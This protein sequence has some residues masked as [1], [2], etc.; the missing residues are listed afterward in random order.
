MTPDA[1][2][3]ATLERLFALT[4]FGEKL[5][6]STPRA[7]NAALGDPLGAYRSVLIGGTNGKGSTSAFL[8]AILRRAGLK[9]GLFTSPHLISFQERIRIDGKDLS[10]ESV[11]ALAE[12]IFALEALRPSFFEATWAMAA[13][14]FALAG[15]DVAIFEVGLGGRLDATNTCDPAASAVVSVGLDHTQVLGDTLE[16]IAFEKAGIFR[17]GRPALTADPVALPLLQRAAP[18][19]VAL[20]RPQP[21]LPPLPLPGAFQRG[22]AALALALAASIGVEPDVAALE[23]VRWPGRGERIGNVILDCAHNPHAAEAL[24]DWLA[25]RV[26]S[27]LHLIFGAMRGK[28]VAGVLAPLAPHVASAAVVTP[29]YPRR[30]AAAEVLPTARA[31][32]PAAEDGGTVA[33]ALAAAPAGHL[34][35]VTGSCFLVGEAKAHLTGRE[36]PE[37]GLRTTA[38]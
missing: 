8:E 20:V 5:D 6:L 31:F 26:K 10:R 22:N 29:D 28:D 33:E 35:L 21:D 38:R 37:C 12:R 2:Y 32:W 34:T 7:L 18:G 13:L 17:A 27:P 4:R 14:G 23:D 3:R 1:A 24:A 36:F 15:V 25:E 30:M 11:N 16:Q 9:V 19:P